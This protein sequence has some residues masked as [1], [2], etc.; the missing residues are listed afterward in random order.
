MLEARCAKRMQEGSLLLQA[1]HP[2]HK[3][4]EEMSGENGLVKMRPFRDAHYS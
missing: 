3:G 4:I 1:Q 2:C